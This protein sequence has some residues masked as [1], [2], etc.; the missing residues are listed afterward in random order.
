M[1]NQSFY[2]RENLQQP[3][4][5]NEMQLSGNPNKWKKKLFYNMDSAERVRFADIRQELDKSGLMHVSNNQIIRAM[6]VCPDKDKCLDKI[7]RTEDN[8]LQMN[9]NDLQEGDFEE[10][11]RMNCLVDNGSYDREGRPI[12]YLLTRNIN[13]RNISIEHFTRFWVFASDRAAAR[14][15]SCTDEILLIVD[16]QN[17][18]FSQFYRNHFQ[19]AINIL[20]ELYCG[21]NSAIKIINGGKIF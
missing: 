11:I 12:L 2:K 21:R 8:R 19:A 18:G 15:K 10:L 1:H 6:S 3:K 7:R 14:M 4:V 5:I 20:Q 13:F 9:L 17:F 16:F